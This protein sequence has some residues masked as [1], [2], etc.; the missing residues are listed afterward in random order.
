M[1]LLALAAGVGLAALMLASPASAKEA[2]C[3]H[4]DDFCTS[5]KR[6]NG[7]RVLRVETF[8]FTGRVKICV[9][10]PTGAR[11]CHRFRL[12]KSGDLYTAKARW[13]TSYPNR[14]RGLYRVTFFWRSTKLGPALSFRVL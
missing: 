3:A 2:Y 1:K 7:V 12:L 9:K 10:G 13:G 8:T 14:G 4:T 11:V 6:V 5:V